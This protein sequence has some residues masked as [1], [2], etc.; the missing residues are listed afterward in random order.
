MK[1]INETTLVDWIYNRFVEAVR[2]NDFIQSSIYQDILNKTI[3]LLPSGRKYSAIKRRAK[4][5]QKEITIA[6]KSGKPQKLQYTGTEFVADF[7][8]VIAEYEI[9]LRNM[10]FD[11]DTIQYLLSEKKLSYGN[12]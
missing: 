4:E 8:R 2:K 1:T 3:N 7:N 11:E 12:D 5:H 10:D 9:E 6:Y